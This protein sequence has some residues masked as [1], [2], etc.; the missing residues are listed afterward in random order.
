MC[1][2]PGL[3]MFAYKF[4]LNFDECT[5]SVYHVYGPVFNHDSFIDKT[6]ALLSHFPTDWALVY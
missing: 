1:P 4:R 3:H 6:K 5:Q 2:G